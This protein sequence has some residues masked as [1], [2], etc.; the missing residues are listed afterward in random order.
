MKEKNMNTSTDI[1]PKRRNIL[2]NS[3]AQ[4]EQ[5]QAIEQQQEQ[6]K[7]ADKQ[8]EQKRK[9]F[10][11]KP[12]VKICAS[13]GNAFWA[14]LVSLVLTLLASYFVANPQMLS[15]VIAPIEKVFSANIAGAA[16]ASSSN[17]QKSTVN[18][19]IEVRKVLDKTFLDHKEQIILEMGMTRP[20]SSNGYTGTLMLKKIEITPVVGTVTQKAERVVEF[21]QLPTNDVS[22]LPTEQSFSLRSDKEMDAREDV[23]LRAAEWEW[24]V[25][26]YDSFGLPERYTALVIYR[27]EEKWLDYTSVQVEA[28]YAGK[29]SKSS[30]VDDGNQAGTQDNQPTQTSATPEPEEVEVVINES[31]T[32]ADLQPEQAEVEYEPQALSGTE[33]ADD[34]NRSWLPLAIGTAATVAASGGTAAAVIFYRRKKRQND[35]WENTDI[36]Q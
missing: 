32:E 31:I 9:T 15:A 18:A 17:V 22:Q 6:K 11:A 29:A 21:D 1:L 20:Y 10:L 4:I 14:L 24:T 25:T 3:R 23:D 13:I 35:A 28:I 34:A 26:Q 8:R 12:S 16:P 7:I 5:Q 2:L 30:F 33:D 27:G 36:D 19:E